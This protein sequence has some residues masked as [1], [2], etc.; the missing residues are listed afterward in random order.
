KS[1]EIAGAMREVIRGFPEVSLVSSQTGRNDSG[2]D[3]FGPNRNELLL[4]LRPYSSWPAG[5]Q[6]RHLVEELSRRLAAEIPGVSLNFPP[7]IADTVTESVTGSLAD[8]AVI[9]TGPNLAELR[10]LAAQTLD[11]V[12]QVP[13]AADSAIEQEP[14]QAQLRIVI[15]R[16]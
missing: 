13:G 4:V 9:L 1:A 10:N 16:D 7:P 12:R 3:P 5:E 15:D 6:K 11:L 8:L 14:E 2:T